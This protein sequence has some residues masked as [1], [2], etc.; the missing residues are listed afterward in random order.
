MGA[1]HVEGFIGKKSCMDTAE[2]NPCAAFPDQSPD[3]VTPQSVPRMDAYPDYIAGFNAQRVDL[4]ERLIDNV[5][6]SELHWSGCC[7]HEEPPRRDNSSSKG[8]V[9]GIHQV[10]G[11]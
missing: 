4:L 2:N 11:H 10:D 7:D 3:L 8:N 1:A 5:W 6:V 9:A